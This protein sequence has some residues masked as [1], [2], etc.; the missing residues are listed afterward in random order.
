M[1]A[2]ATMLA[3]KKAGLCVRCGKPARPGVTECD[4]HR[5]LHAKRVAKM[6]RAR[7]K[8]GLCRLC[9]KPAV[10]SHCEKHMEGRRAQDRKRKRKRK[11]RAKPRPT[12]M[13][14]TEVKVERG[15]QLSFRFRRTN[16]G[17]VVWFGVTAVDVPSANC[18]E[19]CEMDRDARR[20][21]AITRSR[22]LATFYAR[23]GITPLTSLTPEQLAEDKRDEMEML[24]WM[25]LA[26]R[27]A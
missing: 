24:S 3:R 25:H 22:R 4:R 9:G 14:V 2:A 1:T 16:A 7:K 19:I 15:R 27:L 26:R 10:A 17:R 6:R 20:H 11:S 12:P 21:R 18:P 5:A 23:H 13:P 8:A